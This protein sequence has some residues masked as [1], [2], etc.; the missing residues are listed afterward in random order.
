[1]VGVYYRLPDQAEPINEAL[2]QIQ[3]A[4]RSQSLFLL[5]DFNHP[6]ICWKS[7]TASCRQHNTL[8][9]YIEHNFLSQVIDSPIRGGAILDLLV[10]NINELIGDVK[11]GGSL[12]CS[13]HTLVKFAVLREK[14]RQR[15]KSGP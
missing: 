12:G 1:V 2:L 11:I 15:V 6:D 7:N 13:D 10:T 5:G 3:E 4:S 9:E 14:V 8:L